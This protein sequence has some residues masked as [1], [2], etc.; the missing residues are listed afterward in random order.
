MAFWEPV[1]TGPR[2]H[3]GLFLSASFAAF[4]IHSCPSLPVLFTEQQVYLLNRTITPGPSPSQKPPVAASQLQSH[5]QSL[6]Q[7]PH[8]LDGPR[9]P[10][11]P[12]LSPSILLLQADW[13]SCCSLNT[14]SGPAR[15][16]SLI[17][18]S[19]PGVFPRCPHGSPL[20]TELHLHSGSSL[21]R[22]VL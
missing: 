8:A 4:S 9:A 11:T 15:G 17:G 22:L 7:G 2:S 13:P 10:L 21:A 19:V 12:G 3:H 6:P 14:S 16:L 20:P 18:P 5:I 1:S